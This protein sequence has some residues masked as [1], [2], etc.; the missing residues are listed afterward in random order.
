[1]ATYIPG[2]ED[3]IP[4]SQPFVPDYKFLSDVLAVRQDRYDKNYK[5]LND[6]YGKVVYADLTRNENKYVRDQYAEQLAPQIKQISGLDLS[7][8][9][10]VDAAYAL[11]KPFYN[12]ESVIKDLTATA[13]LKNERQKM[14]AFKDS[15]IRAVREK[16]WDY[17]QQGLDIWEEDFKNADR[18]EALTMGLPQ[19]IEDVDL[20]EW[21]E[22]LLDDSK[23]GDKEDII[24]SQDNKWII[25]MKS[26]S[27]ITAAPTGRMVKVKDKEGKE[28]E[29]P[30]TKNLALEFIKDRLA[31]DPTVQSAY[32]LR[33]YVDMRNYVKENSERLGGDEAAKKQWA[34]DTIEKYTKNFED[35]IVELEKIKATNKVTVSSWEAYA[36]RVGIK[37]GSQKDIDF[38]NSLDELELVNETIQGKKTKLE[39]ITAPTSDLKDLLHKAYTSAMGTQMGVDMLS[40]ATSYANKTMTRDMELNPEWKLWAEHKYRMAEKRLQ[41]SIDANKKEKENVKTTPRVPI[42]RRKKGDKSNIQGDFDMVRENIDGGT[43]GY[44]DA[45]SYNTEDQGNYIEN[46]NKRRKDIIKTVYSK[47][48]MDL[49][50]DPSTFTPIFSPNLMVSHGEYAPGTLIKEGDAP[51]EGEFDNRPVSGMVGDGTVAGDIAAVRG[52]IENSKEPIEER[53]TFYPK[54]SSMTWNEFDA[55]DDPNEIHNM[56]TEMIRFIDNSEELFPSYS[57]VSQDMRT[58]ISGDIINLRGDMAFF[59]EKSLE[60]SEKYMETQRVLMGSD[61]YFNTAAND[62]GSIF[63][64]DGIRINKEEW[65]ERYVNKWTGITNEEMSNS[66]Y[67]S[68]NDPLVTGDWNN[69]DGGHYGTNYNPNGNFDLPDD[70]MG[71]Q[72]TPIRN[73]IGINRDYSATNPA[74]DSLQTQMFNAGDPNAK[75]EM[76]VQNLM[77]GRYWQF[78]AMGSG[79]TDEWGN[80][81]YVSPTAQ[82]GQMYADAEAY[83]DYMYKAVNQ[84]MTS[85]PENSKEF[86]YNFSSAMEGMPMQGDDMSI[87]PVYTL[88]YDHNSGDDQNAGAMGFF[89]NIIAAVD[90]DPTQVSI[91]A[92][93][94]Y[95]AA[96]GESL[97][98]VNPQMKALFNEAYNSV[99]AQYGNPDYAP[100]EG[101]IIMNI[102]Y[103]KNGA[104]ENLEAAEYTITFNKDWVD[105]RLA[106]YNATKG[107]Y[108]DVSSMV[109]NEKSPDF[110]KD[111]SMTI[112]IEK[113]I[114]NNIY[115]TG[116]VSEQRIMAEM[117]Q[118]NGMINRTIP[119]GGAMTVYEISPGTYMYSDW[120]WD[121]QDGEQVKVPLNNMQVPKESIGNILAT[122]EAKLQQIATSNIDLIKT[123]NVTNN[124][125]VE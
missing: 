46:F 98:Q 81:L 90:G 95:M 24:I 91:V 8:Q 44:S 67:G 97:G 20:V 19:Y 85:T 71:M 63:D 37:P 74:P 100:K 72:N 111:Y 32:H 7:L 42:L 79:M 87:S 56:Y 123:Y 125:R 94:D 107:D 64:K 116:N 30:E 61:T 3:S 13:T 105:G 121:I 75:S 21:A 11:F 58:E 17:G 112:L 47:V 62:G 65:V 59:T 120:Y 48:A 53:V 103:S 31:D 115:K 10:N 89:N 101:G 70:L 9:E 49:N 54:K 114:D 18:Q 36:K 23:L 39:Q 73:D 68:I 122:Q 104:G 15:P 82:T 28:I 55:I 66:P 80:Q 119:N 35:D 6:V 43:P 34:N 118:N 1:M 108:A 110:F 33:N 88:T 84:K 38:L 77:G 102:S 109:T 78:N 124:Y 27:L 51:K 26:G 76:Q 22:M 60:L 25:K 45:I 16:Y 52:T 93:G 40:A 2:V 50:L 99:I 57:N 96:S 12:N 86:G 106:N 5:Q 92:G 4:Q 83:Y 117:R 29:V 41:A 69:L 113:E 14:A